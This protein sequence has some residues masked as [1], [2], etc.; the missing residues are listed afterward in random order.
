MPSPLYLCAMHYAS[1]ENLSKSF[2]IR[3]LFSQISFYIEE[4]D[5]IALVARNGSGK[6]TLMKII[7][8]LDTADSGTVWVHKEI[9]TI[10]LQQDT[11]FDGSKTIWDNVLRLQNP[12]VQAVKAYEE[13]LENNPNDHDTIGVLMSRIDELDAWS[14]ESNVKQVLGKLNIHHLN[15]KMGNL[16]GGQKKRVALAQ[17]LIEAQLYS[18]KCLLLMDEPTNHLDVEMIEWLE[19][20]LNASKVTLLLVTHDRYFLDAVCNEII[21]I[22]AE[23]V[24]THKGGYDYFLEQKALRIEVQQS[25]LQKDKNIYRKELEWMR[26]QPKA[27]T[28]KSKSRQDAFAQVE[29]RVKQQNETAEVSLQ[30]KM[31]R[32][33]GKVLEMKKVYKSYGQLPIMKGFDYTFKKGERVGVVG[34]N[35]VGKSTF[36]KIAL[37]LEAP[38]S[39]KINHGDTVVFGNFSQDG[40]QYKEDKRSIEYVKDMAE[41]FPLADGSKISASQFMEKFGFGAEQQY[42]LLSKLSGG[43]KRRLHLMSVLFTNPNFLVLD[44]PTNDLDLQTLST[45]EE[46]LLDYPGCIL[47]VS[48]DRY[49]MDRM[50]DHLFA[51]EGDGFIRD[52]PGNYTQYRQALASGAFEKE[53]TPSREQP[54]AAGE[55]KPAASATNTAVKKLSFKEKFELE[56]LEKDMPRLQKEKK[57]LEEKLSSTQDYSELQ[58]AADRISAIIAELDQKEMRWLELSEKI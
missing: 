10:M 52:Y 47:I 37:Q 57:L 34:K 18:G 38:D 44:E 5:K 43:E 19:E 26:K 16:S 3:T 27:R 28:T 35:G 12:V 32:L 17:A 45:L 2:G 40:L 33:G 36:L 4:G 8:G 14:F 20:Y 46:F 11:H 48:H 39:G 13:C 49:F 29:E 42:T 25:E 7:A 51:F 56:Q 30:M 55:Q 53:T 6:S 24:Y 21:E 23:K 22:D 41:F 58:K 9:K 15:H 50:V 31:T 1:I 54:Q